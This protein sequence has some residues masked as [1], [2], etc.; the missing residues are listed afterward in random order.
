MDFLYNP[1]FI[2]HKYPLGAIDVYGARISVYINRDFRIDDLRIHIFSDNGE[3]VNN[4]ELFY[5]NNVDKYNVYVTNLNID[6]PG[7]YWYYFSFKDCYGLHYLGAKD[8]LDCY[9]TDLNPLAYQLSVFDKFKSD[10]NWFKG[11]IMYQIFPDRF[12]NYKNTY[13]KSYGYIHENWADIPDYKMIN[14]KIHNND[15]FGGNLIGI[16]KKLNYLKELNVSIIYLNPIFEAYSNHRYDTA[17]YSKIDSLLGN[18]DD[19]KSLCEK[20]RKMG[21]R[22]IIDGVFNHTGSDSIYFNKEN[23][24]DVIG[25]YNSKNS[26]Y[27]SW[28]KFINYPNKYDSWWGF[29]T[30]PAVNQNC[31]DYLEYITGENGIISKWLNL[32]A[33]GIRLDVV[34]ELNDN[35]I[36]LINKAVNKTKSDNI[37]I[38]EVWE[39]ASNKM[40]YG[41]RRSYFNGNQLDSVMNYP[42]KDAIIDFILNKNSYNLSTTLRR[43]V[44]NYPNH[45]LNLLM[46]VLST[47]DTARII[48]VLSGINMENKSKDEKA[49]FKLMMQDYYKAK[50]RLKMASALLYTLPGVPCIFY[51]DEAG[52]EGD[53]DPFCRKTMPWYDFDLEIFN[54][55]KELG[56]IRK[57]NVF[58]DGL[59]NE[60]FVEN[61]IFVFERYNDNCV[62][63]ILSNSSNNP[64]SYHI[65]GYDLID[66]CDINCAL[67]LPMTTKIIKKYY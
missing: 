16:E 51:G 22:I 53:K 14:G 42:L 11:G 54:W 23:R 20:A 19:F 6:K 1:S 34:D 8:N 27:Y 55:Y 12:Y 25:A 13:N 37:V 7:I 45:V 58:V 57:D 31:K 61:G 26:K 21:I 32:G 10:I 49:S 9:L 15:F 18:E 47:H 56:N 59:Y 5:S 30:L 52:V 2:K 44:N 66:K 28:Y 64:F 24:Y 63:V 50:A 3:E 17:D 65:N 4:F 48:T 36:N 67:V 33:S 62:I 60:L 41:K 46:N 39:D 43:I 29:D 38:G 35:F 40:A